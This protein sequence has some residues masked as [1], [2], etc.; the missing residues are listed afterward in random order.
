MLGCRLAEEVLVIIHH[1]DN[2]VHLDPI[3]EYWIIALPLNA[4]GAS[5]A[6]R[7]CRKLADMPRGNVAAR[8]GA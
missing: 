8:A 1:V 2:R 5:Y 3:E 7:R 4:R 6:D